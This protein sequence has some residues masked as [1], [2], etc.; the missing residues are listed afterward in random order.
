M[1]ITSTTSQDVG[2][3]GHSQTVV[4][5]DKEVA[6]RLG[7]LR[8]ILDIPMRWAAEM[9]SWLMHFVTTPPPQ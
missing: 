7:Q 3:A 8:R 1:P 2:L 6:A 9:Q 5:F 4:V